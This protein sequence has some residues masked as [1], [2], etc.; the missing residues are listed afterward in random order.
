MMPVT[1]A[2]MLTPAEVGALRSVLA[3]CRTLDEQPDGLLGL[4]AVEAADLAYRLA[5]LG[6]A[7]LRAGPE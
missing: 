6:K 3:Y 5:V 1:V 2:L 7:M 4:S